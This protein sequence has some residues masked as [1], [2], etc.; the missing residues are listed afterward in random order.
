MACRWRCC[1][2]DP[3]LFP[4]VVSARRAREIILGRVLRVV[5]CLPS[6]TIIH[7]NWHIADLDA[8]DAF[9]AAVA[10]AVRDRAPDMLLLFEPDSL[11]NLTDSAEVSTPFPYDNAVY[12]PHVYTDVFEDGWASQD[13]AAVAASVAAAD[14]E[15]RAHGTALFVGE[16][17]HDPSTEQGLRYIE[18]ALD[19][20]DTNGASWAFWLY[21][22]W[23]QGRWGLY[24]G[25]AE[26][27]GALREPIAD[28]LARPF[29]AAIDGIVEGAAWDGATLAVTIAEAGPGEHLIATPGRT[30]PDTVE[31]TCDDAPADAT[32]EGGRIRVRCS[33][34]RL[35]ITGD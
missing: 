20:F 24:E 4:G 15:A 3:A 33:G 5:I 6:S 17:G 29:P 27:R 28:L 18:V 21:E 22:E 10:G 13:E 2:F 35:I 9:H 25:D 12:A 32:R 16:F 11:R 7:W 8:L 34:S 30:W 14:A 1:E 31:V 26:A 23:S 19:A